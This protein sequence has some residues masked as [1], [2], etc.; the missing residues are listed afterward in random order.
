MESIEEIQEEIVSEFAIFDSWNDK[1]EYLIDQGRLLPPM[2]DTLKT[3][4]RLI[5]GCQSQVWLHAFAENGLIHY[6]A[7]SD[8]IITRGMVALLLRIFNK[9]KAEE[10]A[11][12][13]VT[14]AEASGL[15]AHLS[16]TRANG[17][18][19]MIRQI[20]TDAIALSQKT[21]S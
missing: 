4:E 7:D 13:H 17:L 14:F 18:V 9:R 21:S 11:S 8:A 3:P 15:S 19:S 6:Q 5:P 20:K 1:Y 12:A 16:P 10:I 2:P